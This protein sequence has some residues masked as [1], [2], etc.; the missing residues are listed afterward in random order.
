MF[1]FA[2]DKLYIVVVHAKVINIVF[3]R[4]KKSFRI[5]QY[6]EGKR[7]AEFLPYCTRAKIQA[8]WLISAW[9]GEDSRE[10]RHTSL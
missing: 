7:D 2:Y 10:Q 3:Y 8:R 1:A 4:P 5:Y 6:N 9:T